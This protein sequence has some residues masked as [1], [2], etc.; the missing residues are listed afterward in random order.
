M[1]SYQGPDIDNP[2]QIAAGPDGAMWFTNYTPGTPAPGTIGRISTKGTVTVFPSRK[3]N[4]P[5]GITSGPDGA[6]W[7][8]NY[9]GNTI[10]RITTSGVVTTYATPFTLSLIQFIAPGPAGTLW[11]TG[12]TDVI[13]EISG[14]KT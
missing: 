10:G 12:L 13:G 2:L 8:T 4:G 1:T 14:I 9:N 3:I 6:L 7:F 11:F 5:F